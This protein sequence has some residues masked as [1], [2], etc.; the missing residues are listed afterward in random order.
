MHHDHTLTHTGT[1]KHNHY[2]HTVHTGTTGQKYPEDQSLSYLQ[3]TQD[4]AVSH[5]IK[6]IN[7]QYGVTG[8]S[9]IHAQF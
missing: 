2:N 5:R 1:N 8:P 3:Y 4:N 9:L 7:N 6:P